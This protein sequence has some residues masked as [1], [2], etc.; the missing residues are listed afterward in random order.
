MYPGCQALLCVGGETPQMI[1][2]VSTGTK[3]TCAILLS[4]VTILF[5][6]IVGTILAA[7][8]ALWLQFEFPL[9]VIFSLSIGIVTSILGDRFVL[10]FMSLMRYFR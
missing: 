6:F 8:L 2:G 7:G 4:V 5:R 9:N 3:L 10:G 1:V